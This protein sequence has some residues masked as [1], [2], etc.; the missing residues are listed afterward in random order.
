M[1]ASAISLI[2][3]ASGG[4]DITI[5][6][7]VDVDDT[8][9]IAIAREL[10]AREGCVVLA[11]PRQIGLGDLING[12][13]AAAPEDAAFMLWSD[14]ISVTGLQWDHELALGCM[15]FPN[16]PLWLDSVHLTGAGQ[17]I[18]PPKWRAAQGD[19]CPKLFPFWFV[20]TAVEEIDAYIFGMQRVAL[21]AKAAGPRGM[22]TTRMRDV[23]FWVDLFQK[24]RAQRLLQAREIADKLG[25]TPV[26][27]T[28]TMAQFFHA[29]M[30]GMK[31]RAKALTDTFG[32][33]GEP[34][35]T[36]IA[37][38]AAAEELMG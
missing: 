11:R 29:R 18:L 13:A 36:Y 20:D 16:R 5:T 32:E 28:A 8:D 33:E 14:R 22:R 35:E 1:V 17:F 27:G 25:V 34:D 15:Q 6:L 12:L 38:K 37:A 2:R 7:G 3:L 9:T 21:A 30:E 24:Q 10:Q 26:P 19:P 31:E 23:V 4:H